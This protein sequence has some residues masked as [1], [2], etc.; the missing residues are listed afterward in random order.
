MREIDAEV[1]H[2]ICIDLPLRGENVEVWTNHSQFDIA[3]GLVL[4]LMG[5]H[6]RAL[7][8]TD[9]ATTL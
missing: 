7:A 5:H 9:G 4:A 8:K 1:P 2:K 6:R 3:M